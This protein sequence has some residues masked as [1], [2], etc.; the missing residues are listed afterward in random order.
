MLAASAANLLP[1]S[2]IFAQKD[3]L[4][5]DQTAGSYAF[6][7]FDENQDELAR[8]K[9]QAGIVGE[10]ERRVLEAAGLTPGMRGA[11]PRVRPGNR[12]HAAG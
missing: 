10:L 5:S 4:M 8:L 2:S 9:R 6:G 11:R 3:S 7:S 12:E 1:L